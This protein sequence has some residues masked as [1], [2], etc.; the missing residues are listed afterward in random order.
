MIRMWLSDGIYTTGNLNSNISTNR[1]PNIC[2]LSVPSSVN[3]DGGW[4]APYVTTVIFSG[5]IRSIR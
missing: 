5:K 4:T 2:S 3:Y 1:L